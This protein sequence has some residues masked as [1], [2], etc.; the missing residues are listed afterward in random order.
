[1]SKSRKIKKKNVHYILYANI[2]TSKYLY[3]PTRV[4]ESET[5]EDSLDSWVSK[6]NQSCHFVGFLTKTGSFL[7]SKVTLG[8]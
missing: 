5:K 8:K 1:M 6:S 7:Y 4:L 3:V 2:H